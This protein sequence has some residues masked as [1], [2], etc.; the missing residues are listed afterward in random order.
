[1]DNN[2]PSRQDWVF[3]G[4]DTYKL[5]K[6]DLMKTYIN[7]FLIRTQRM[8]KYEGLPDTIPQK[9]LELLLQVNGSA[10]IAKV[11]NELYA[12]R[13]GL[14]GVPNA[15]YLPT[16]AIVANPALHYNKSL[17][18]DKDCVVILNDS[19]YQGLMPYIR[20]NAYLLAEC[21]ISFKFATINTRIPAIVKATDDSSLKSASEFF[22]QIELGDELGVI[23]DE[24]FEKQLEV[25]NYASSGTNVTQL[26]ELK[27]YILGSFYN[28]LG[29]Q[30]QFN[31]KRE[32]INTAESTLNEDV[33]Y[34]LLDD[35]LEQR[36]LG[37]E[38]INNMF[39]T[40]I[41]VDF[42]S[43]WKQ[44]RQQAEIDMSLKEAELTTETSTIEDTEEVQD[45]S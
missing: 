22:K 29:L 6:S 10:V 2:I 40:N 32:A 15:Y 38:K 30:S 42:D 19:L 35:M 24:D 39:G 31:M 41:T 17:E 37:L 21:D 9:D 25:Y 26:I 16:I 20:Q 4:V 28:E 5:H 14:G 45:E 1:M 13:G 27:Q 12:F 7:K 44:L 33:L 34:P 3:G 18:I 36:R 23:M 11:N 43:V 8:F